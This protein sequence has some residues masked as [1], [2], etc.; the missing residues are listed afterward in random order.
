MIEFTTLPT[1]LYG[2]SQAAMAAAT[3]SLFAASVTGI[4]LE[5]SGRVP[6]GHYEWMRETD[7][8]RTVQ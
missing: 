5:S 4:Y 2:F 7:E 8:V 3:V 6:P 1:V